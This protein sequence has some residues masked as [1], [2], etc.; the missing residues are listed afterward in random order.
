MLV[1]LRWW[2]SVDCLLLIICCWL[3]VVDSSPWNYHVDSAIL[4]EDNWWL[5]A[6]Q[7]GHGQPVGY[8]KW[9]GMDPVHHVAGPTWPLS[10]LSSE[11]SKP[12][13]ISPVGSWPMVAWFKR[14]WFIKMSWESLILWV[15]VGHYYLLWEVRSHDCWGSPL[16]EVHVVNLM[17]ER[18][19]RF[20]PP[21]MITVHHHKLPM[22]LL[23]LMN[24]SWT[25]LW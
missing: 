17:T 23:S 21:H 10:G 8:G 16:K 18:I 14:C 20:S 25:T 3:S 24:H 6:N 4:W 9:L 7:D 2:W 5:M 11:H 15:I 19:Y 13:P 12:P 22:N 1:L